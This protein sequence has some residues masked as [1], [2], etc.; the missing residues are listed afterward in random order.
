VTTGDAA[1]VTVRR[2]WHPVTAGGG[3][4]AGAVG[5]ATVQLLGAGPAWLILLVWLLTG[6]SA[7][8]ATSGST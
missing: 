1:R 4:A 6:A 8:F 3:L 2:R 7:G 5:V